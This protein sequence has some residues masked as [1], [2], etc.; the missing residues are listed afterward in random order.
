MFGEKFQ[1]TYA[2]TDQGVKNTKR[3]ALFTVITNLVVMAGTGILYLVMG[4]FM[5]TL[6][7]E[8]AATNILVPI[9]LIIAFLV[10]SFITHYL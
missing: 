10:L 1:R 4:S 5:E 9:L 8:S 2:L 6:I 7:S 3:G